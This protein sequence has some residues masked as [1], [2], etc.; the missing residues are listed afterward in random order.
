MWFE[1]DVLLILGVMVEGCAEVGGGHAGVLQGVSHE[2]LMIK[3]KRDN[4]FRWVGIIIVS[5]D[6]FH[7]FE[8]DTTINQL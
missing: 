4:C 2:L 5:N 8:S 3:I 6:G 1:N 7:S